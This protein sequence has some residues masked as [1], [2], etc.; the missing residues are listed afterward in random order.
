MNV[1]FHIINYNVNLPLLINMRKMNICKSTGCKSVILSVLCVLVCFSTGFRSGNYPQI[2]DYTQY[3]TPVRDAGPLNTRNA[4]AVLYATE[5][6]IFRK[7][8]KKIPLSAL[9]LYYSS[10]NQSDTVQYNKGVKIE[11]CF[12]VMKTTGV[13]AEY[14]WP[15]DRRSDIP[16]L[17]FST[18]IA[19][20]YKVKDIRPVFREFDKNPFD[21]VQESLYD[22]GPVIVELKWP[23][24]WSESD[25]KQV[26]PDTL[27]IPPGEFSLRAICLTGFN[28]KEKYFMFK[29]ANGPG[30]GFNGYGRIAYEDLRKFM[31]R[32]WTVVV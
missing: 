21:L 17:L 16:G 26:L 19:E 2:L 27:R 30:W 6:H 28:E 25:G 23:S 3:L 22:K 13:M 20:R 31:T 4:F 15:Y 7:T 1:F 5:Y 9:H 32:A 29:A 14:S 18:Q 8:G 10:H 11:D 24:S 12:Q